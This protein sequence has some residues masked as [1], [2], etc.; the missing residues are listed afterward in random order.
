[1]SNGHKKKSSCRFVIANET[2][3]LLNHVKLHC[4]VSKELGEIDF[5]VSQSHRQTEKSDGLENG[6]P[7]IVISKNKNV[8]KISCNR[9]IF[10]SLWQKCTTYASNILSESHAIK[11]L[12]RIQSV[13]LTVNAK[14]VYEN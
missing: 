12:I 8:M 7:L 2:L 6:R 1:M 4:L 10:S 9:V 11:I 3:F 14:T 13:L 5:L